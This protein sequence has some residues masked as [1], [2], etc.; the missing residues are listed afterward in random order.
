M[1]SCSPD[2]L[3]K[4]WRQLCSA[5]VASPLPAHLSHSNA[6]V[7]TTVRAPSLSQG[8]PIAQPRCGKKLRKIDAGTLHLRGSIS[9][10]PTISTAN[11]HNENVRRYLLRPED[12]PWKG[13]RFLPVQNDLRLENTTGIWNPWG[14]GLGLGF[15]R[16]R[17]WG[18]EREIL[19]D[20]IHATP[21]TF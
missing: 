18:S 16:D 1:T 12:L 14:I 17:V 19:T 8:S 5:R 9:R 20:L 3:A 15:G 7:D 10:Q 4:S 11:R 6:G 21:T 13:T 2:Q